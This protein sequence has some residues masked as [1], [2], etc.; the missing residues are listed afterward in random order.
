VVDHIAFLAQQ[1]MQAPISKAPALMGNCLH[2]IPQID[3]IYAAA[4]IPHGHATTAQ[5]CARPPL[6]HLKV[7]MR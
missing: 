2:P 3:I 7:S 5:N 6:A 1:H 4:L